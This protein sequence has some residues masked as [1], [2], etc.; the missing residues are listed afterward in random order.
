MGENL[1]YLVV[2]GKP[3]GPFTTDELK[4][5]PVKPDSFLKTAEMDDYK[6]AH[7]IEELRS[8]LG[9]AKEFTAPQYYAGFDL[10]LLATAIDWFIVFGIFAFFELLVALYIDDQTVTQQNIASG[11]LLL[12]F[13]KLFYN[14]YMENYQ[15][16]T[17]GKKLL[18][19]KVVNMQGLNPSLKQNINRNISKIISTL[20]LFA[21][22][23][24]LFLNKQ[25]QTLHDKLAN[26]L[27]VKDRLI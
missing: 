11:L 12:P 3:T 7:E 4:S 18:S 19:I 6:E 9:F 23:F 1:Y 15:Q 2:E 21:G 22:Y 13:L 20:P 16:A 24:Y 27:V 25:Q 8:A 17:I 26:T 10:R 5:K 14:I